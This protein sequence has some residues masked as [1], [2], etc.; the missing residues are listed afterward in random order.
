MIPVFYRNILMEVVKLNISRI[1]NK[2]ILSTKAYSRIENQ[3]LLEVSYE[4]NDYNFYNIFI[5]IV[6]EPNCNGREII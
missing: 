4:R 5:E 2:Y 1:S 6:N 3:I